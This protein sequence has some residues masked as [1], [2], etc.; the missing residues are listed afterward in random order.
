L[1][2]KV[3]VL[4]DHEHE[5]SV[6]LDYEEI[7]PEI[8]EAY[9]KETRDIAIPGFRKGKAPRHLI[10]KYYGDLIEE[11]AS[12]DIAKQKFYVLIEE[13]EKKPISVPSMTD[14]KFEAGKSLEFAVKYEI[15]PEWDVTGYLDL[16]I[17]KPLVNVTE[18]VVD[19]ELFNMLKSQATWAYYDVIDDKYTRVTVDLQK[20]D[21]EGNIVVGEK[22]ENI[23]FDFTDQSLNIKIYEGAEGKKV[24]E[25]FRF[26]FTSI[27][28]H[29]DHTHEVD[30]HNEALIK[31]IEKITLPEINEDLAK[32]LSRDKASSET[33]LKDLIRNEL[34]AFYERQSSETFENNLI[35][36]ILDNNKDFIVPEGFVEKLALEFTEK[37]IEESKK[38]KVNIDR[39][40][41]E[42]MSK[43]RAQVSGKIEIILLSIAKKEHISVTESEVDEFLS[44]EAESTGI[45]LDK[46]KN[47]YKMNDLRETL[48]RDKVFKFLKEKNQ[49]VIINK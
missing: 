33:E 34:T 21:S 23:S 46:L 41:I 25:T 6:V 35:T 14:L 42:E 11:R 39:K 48:L 27:H 7:L 24:A 43:G 9:K 12:E 22:Y 13:Q 15:M 28:Q 44:K 31:K 49:Q 8:E 2:T 20:L 1:E 26:H 5:L 10:K 38:Y 29:D 47:Y 36:K 19:E 18:E 32:K 45:S 40:R 37:E 30:V 16:H 3:N 17:E 4:S